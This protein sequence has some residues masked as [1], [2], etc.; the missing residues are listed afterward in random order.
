ML[1]GEDWTAGSYHAGYLVLCLL[2]PLS[3]PS[4]H[5]LFHWSQT[6]YYLL[7]MFWPWPTFNYSFQIYYICLCI[8]DNNAITHSLSLGCRVGFLHDWLFTNRQKQVFYFFI[9]ICSPPTQISSILGH[10]HYVART[11]RPQRTMTLNHPLSK[12][13]T[14]ITPTWHYYS[15]SISDDDNAD[16]V[17]RQTGEWTAQGHDNHYISYP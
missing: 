11:V 7:T 3:S 8:T 14:C 16:M 15:E 1:S 9:M 6:T 13:S 2:V 10:C 5:L 17:S 12:A 4:R